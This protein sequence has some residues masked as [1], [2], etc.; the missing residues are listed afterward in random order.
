M[1]PNG[2]TT[3]NQLGTSMMSDEAKIDVAGAKL[4]MPVTRHMNHDNSAGVAAHLNADA[5]SAVTAL[6]GLIG[7]TEPTTKIEIEAGSGSD[8]GNDVRSP[9]SATADAH[10]QNTSHSSLNQSQSPVSNQSSGF[11]EQNQLPGSTNGIQLPGHSPVV[12]SQAAAGTANTLSQ[13]NP[14]VQSAAASSSFFNSYTHSHP[15]YTGNYPY[16][17][18]AT[19]DS[20]AGY[21]QYANIY[22]NQTEF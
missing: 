14:L 20:M 19:L 3:A 8:S 13:V 4:E 16:V 5:R 17:P 12:T 2:L 1:A 18:G 7:A 9:S 10:G 22:A 21:Q 6:G 15:F 11:G